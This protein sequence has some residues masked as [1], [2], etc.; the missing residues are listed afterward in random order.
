MPA[1]RLDEFALHEARVEH[2]RRDVQEKPA[3]ADTLRDEVGR[4]Q[5]AREPVEQQRVGVGARPVEQR[6]GRDHCA[7][8]IDDAQQ[9][10][11]TDDP[12]VRDRQHGLE[13]AAQCRGAIG[14]DPAA[15]CRREA[16][17]QGVEREVA[18]GLHVNDARE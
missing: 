2:A 6:G 8:R 17:E 7:V 3:V 10:L 12:L 5:A 15:G 16:F 18:G 4:M 9:R 13:H 1:Q 11:V 14:G